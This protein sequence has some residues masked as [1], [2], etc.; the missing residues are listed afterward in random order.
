MHPGRTTGKG[1]S[2]PM[3][4][5]Q[6]PPRLLIV[7][8]ALP[9][10][11]D[12]CSNLCEALQNF[13]SLACSLMGPSRMSVFSLYMV[14]N[15]HEC[16]LPFVQVKGNFARLQACISEL[17][18]L[19]REGCFRPQGT[20]LKLAVVDGLQ[21]FKQYS[22]H[23]TT[24]AALTY[25]SLE[26]TVLTS[27]SGKEVVRQLEEGLKD[28]D[29]VRVR[30]LQV[31]EVTKGILEHMDSASPVEDPSNDESCIL[32][33][34][35]DLQTIDN[36]TVSMEI[37]FKAWLHNSGTDQEHIHLLLP[38]RCFNNISRARDN[39]MCLKCD[40]QER[41]LSP[42]LLPGTADSTLKMDD[43]KG[44]FSTLYQM[45]SQSSAS[46]YKLQVIKALKSSGIC[47]SLTY[48]LPFILRPTSCWQ[49][50]WDELETNQQHFHALCHSLL[51]REWLL[52]AKG[53]LS[54]PG[55]SQRI[56]ASTFYVIMP[57]PSLTLLVKAVATRE[58]ILPNSFPL[59]P[60][61]PP[62]D[63]LKI[64]ESILDSLELEPT[65]NPL[66]V[67]SHLYSHLSSTLVKPQGRLH[68]SWESRA[69]RKHPCKAGQLQTNRVR[70]TVAPLP[71][72]PAPGRAPKMPAASKPSSEAFFMPSEQEEYLSG[73]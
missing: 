15:Q 39:P 9:S 71:M 29:L 20:S 3:H 42:S 68:P 69:P 37:F 41:L 44:D 34:D 24:G 22:R 25:T 57:S 38:S 27:Q 55:Y 21:Q 48:G 2:T 10:W 31:V 23:M 46:R 53:E 18:M 6:Q 67:W 61:D 56:P 1:P 4:F 28:T 60:E 54:S 13:F 40:L 12:I 66:Q 62:D 73:P 19:Q 50:D 14:Q 45:A 47:E 36:D 70:A 35:I 17:R 63:S 52:L 64:V 32:G 58:L 5:D 65:Y 59:L 16:I 8:I 7:H 43:P 33:T 11:A 26:I 49:L 72:I 30:R 51:K